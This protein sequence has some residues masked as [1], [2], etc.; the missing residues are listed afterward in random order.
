MNDIP[1]TSSIPADKD[2]EEQPKKKKKKTASVNPYIDSHPKID[3][4]EDAIFNIESKAY[5]ALANKAHENLADIDLVVE[6]YQ[7]GFD[8]WKPNTKKLTAEQ[9]GFGRVN[10]FFAGGKAAEIDNDLH[11]KYIQRKTLLEKF[12]NIV[13]KA[14]QFNT[15]NLMTLK[16]KDEKD[17]YAQ[18]HALYKGKSGHVRTNKIKNKVAKQLAQQQEQ[19][20]Y[21]A[22][23]DKKDTIGYGKGY[24]PKSSK[25]AIGISVAQNS[26]NVLAAPS[27]DKMNV[28]SPERDLRPVHVKPHHGP[29]A[30]HKSTKSSGH[31]LGNYK[32]DQI[33]GGKAST[34]RSGNADAS[35]KLGKLKVQSPDE[36]KGQ[37]PRQTSISMSMKDDK[38]TSGKA[39]SNAVKSKFHKLDKHS[40]IK[41]DAKTNAD[42]PAAKVKTLSQIKNNSKGPAL[43]SNPNSVSGEAKG[44][45]EKPMK[46][47][48]ADTQQAKPFAV[49]IGKVTPKNTEAPENKPN[50]APKLSSFKSRGLANRLK[51][52]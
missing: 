44:K 8:S 35:Q 34:I 49:K 10:S 45:L 5:D 32:K 36:E 40:A 26:L 52:K 6:V 24:K 28:S 18:G 1:N 13:V 14:G 17:A 29:E 2:K 3:G 19:V 4:H 33:T 16:A 11:E 23:K 51:R 37:A 15:K 22:K 42:A 39:T 48:L 38:R 41:Q 21:V 27:I 25:A 30:D 43:K 46:A 12:Y 50:V 9:I 31:P 47:R 7:R 20:A